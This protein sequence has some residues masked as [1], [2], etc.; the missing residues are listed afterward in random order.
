M[1]YFDE[2]EDE[3]LKSLVDRFDRMVQKGE[4]YFFDVDEFEMIIDHYLIDNQLDKTNLA[5][6]YAMEQHPRIS[7]FMLKKAQMLVSSNHINKAL[8]L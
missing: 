4:R 3:Q 7:S 8:E 5:I 1:E 2:Q 6:K